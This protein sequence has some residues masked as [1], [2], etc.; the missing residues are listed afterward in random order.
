M[1][2]MSLTVSYQPPM[3]VTFRGRQTAS[4]PELLSHLPL[5]LAGILAG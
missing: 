5:E 4:D 1:W 3:T 2:Q